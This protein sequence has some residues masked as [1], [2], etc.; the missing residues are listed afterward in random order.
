MSTPNH[1][2]AGHM[3]SVPAHKQNHVWDTGLVHQHT[4]RGHTHTHE[5]LH[6]LSAPTYVGGHVSLPDGVCRGIFLT[7]W[8]A[9]CPTPEDTEIHLRKLGLHGRI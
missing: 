2:P 3:R 9:S 8:P 5:G 1:I 4:C 7:T 6:F